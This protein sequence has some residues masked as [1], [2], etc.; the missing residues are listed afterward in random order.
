[1]TLVLVT[2]NTFKITNSMLHSH[3]SSTKQEVLKI[4]LQVHP[5]KILI[6]VKVMA[7]FVS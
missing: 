7:K 6:C 3:T 2:L 5:F 1:M 4:A